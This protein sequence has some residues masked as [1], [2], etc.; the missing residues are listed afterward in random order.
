MKEE[1]GRFIDVVVGT[2]E[3]ERPALAVERGVPADGTTASPPAF[4]DELHARLELVRERVRD[5][6]V[7]LNQVDAVATEYL[8]SKRPH[9]RLVR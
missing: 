3:S 5:E 6:A 1:P 4:E 7:H 8:Q 9:L 2:R